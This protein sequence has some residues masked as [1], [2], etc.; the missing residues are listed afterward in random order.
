[1][2]TKADSRP[3]HVERRAKA[4]RVAGDSTREKILAAAE[5]LFADA[6]FDAVSLREIA[7]KAD[8]ALALASYHFGSKDALF[9]AV[10]ARRA[11]SLRS[12]RMERLE[13]LESAGARELL[14]A[15]MAPL[16]EMAVSGEEGSMAYLRVLGRLG[17]QER[18]LELFSR[19]FDETA[20]TFL[21]R[22]G[23]AL[24][25]ADPV[26]LAR[27]FILALEAMLA[28]ASQRRRVD[29]L[30]EGAARASELDKMYPAL[31]R[32]VTAGLESFTRP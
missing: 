28:T 12:K 14:D 32:F 9:E 8:V 30:T 18:G 21:A 31:L 3:E 1:M 23:E 29:S 4:T 7:L 6:S 10:I 13:A 15:F 11:E 19:Y 24:P 25:N 20:N 22:L 2:A 27:A 16:F 26:D 17:E 5:A